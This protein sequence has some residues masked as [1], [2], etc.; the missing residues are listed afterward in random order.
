MDFTY[1]PPLREFVGTNGGKLVCRAPVLLTFFL[2]CPITF[3]GQ[4]AFATDNQNN[5]LTVDR[6]F[7]LRSNDMIL[8]Q[9]H[10]YYD[11][12]RASDAVVAT[13]NSFLQRDRD[14]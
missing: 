8:R 3:Q 2:G 11:A 5:V 1:N 10:F 6:P 14:T 4:N 9:N 13:W 7:R 12:Q